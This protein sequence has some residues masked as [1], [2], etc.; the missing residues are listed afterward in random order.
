MVRKKYTAKFKA[1]VAVEA[2]KEDRTIAELSHT[3]SSSKHD[4]E[5]EK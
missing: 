1:K 3:W 2:I 4:S 5:M